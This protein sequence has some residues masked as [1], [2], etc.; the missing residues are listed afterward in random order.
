MTAVDMR[1]GKVAEEERI[2]VRFQWR[3][4][5]GMAGSGGPISRW[6]SGVLLIL[7]YS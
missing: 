6:S 4:V 3:L 1:Q 7:L 5:V 2:A